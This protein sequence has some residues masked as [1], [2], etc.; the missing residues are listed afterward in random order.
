VTSVR[1]RQS[2]A[3]PAGQP[4]PALSSLPHHDAAEL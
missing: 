4:N 3:P 1:H 2:E